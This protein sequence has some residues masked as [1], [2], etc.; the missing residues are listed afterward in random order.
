MRFGR[1]L[2]TRVVPEWADAYIDYHGFKSQLKLKASNAQSQHNHHYSN[3]RPDFFRNHDLSTA[4]A[5]ADISTFFN[6][7][8]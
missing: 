5:N 7:P 3:P 4:V 6:Y 8:S 2:H 1:Q